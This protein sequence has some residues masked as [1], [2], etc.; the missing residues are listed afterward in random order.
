MILMRAIISTMDLLI[1]AERIKRWG[2]KGG[3]SILDQAVFSGTNFLVSVLLARALSNEDFGAFA[4]GFAMLTFLMQV[5]ISFALEPMSVLGPSHYRDRIGSYLLAQVHLL[6][7]VS[8]PVAIFLAL[9][10]WLDRL[11]GNDSASGPVLIFSAMS[12]PLILFPLLMRRAFYVLLKPASALLGS[13]IYFLVQ[14]S[15]VLLGMHLNV[16]NGVSSVLIF[17]LAGFLSGLLLLLLL[18]GEH[19][20]NETLNLRAVLAETWA[21]GKWL[22]LSGVLIGLATQSQI[23]L[24]G[25]L[26]DIEDAGVVRILQTF[27]QPMMLT[28]TAFSALATPSITADFAVGAYTQMQHKMLR[29]TLVL[30]GMA[31]IYEFLL[32]LFGG[33]VNQI[34]F[35]GKYSAFTSQIP[36]WGL[37]PVLLSFFWGGVIALQASQKPQAMLIISSFW[38]LFSLIPGLVMIPAWG[39]WGATISILAGFVAAFVSTWVLYWR[40]VHQVYMMEKRA[41]R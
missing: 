19:S 28:S 39:V 1:S 6:F 37:V 33:L 15:F 7:L 9:I 2:F 30:G 27:I 5:Y 25:V 12:L 40:W 11:L 4:I 16:L 3:T 26:S 38:A 21:F 24:S 10:I 29:F 8:L 20:P 34:L 22:V 36:I 41:R 14:V 31:L 17:S 18:R 32:I 13:V 35:E 23:Y